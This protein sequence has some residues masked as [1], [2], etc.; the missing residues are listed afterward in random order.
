M[1][2]KQR[3]GGAAGVQIFVGKADTAV[4]LCWWVVSNGMRAARVGRARGRGWDRREQAHVAPREGGAS[5]PLQHGGG[6]GP[7]KDM[8]MQHHGGGAGL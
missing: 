4:L 6:S 3:A 1:C 7:P 5:E 8:H 2:A